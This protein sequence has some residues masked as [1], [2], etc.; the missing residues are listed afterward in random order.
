MNSWIII[1]SLFCFL[2]LAVSLI[3]FFKKSEFN[4]LFSL[5]IFMFAFN[6]FFNILYWMQLESA[7]YAFF[8]FSYYIPLSLYGALFYLYLRGIVYK[9]RLTRKDAFHFIPVALTLVLYGGFYFLKPS[10]KYQV[11]AEKKIMDYII[12]VPYYEQLL[13]IVLGIYTVAIFIKFRNSFPDDGELRVWVHYTILAFTGFTLSFVAYE[14]LMLTGV[15]RV[16]HDY[17][18]S[19]LSALFIG[20]V[21]Y[22][23]YVY[24]AVFNGKSIQ[25]VLP[26]VKYK[27]T[28]LGKQ[29]SVALKEKLIAIIESEKPYLNCDL[30]LIHIA[31]MLDVPRHHASQIINEHFKAG[32]F[33]FINKYRVL[34][35]ERIMQTDTVHHTMESIAYQ[36]G[37]NNRISFYKAFKKFNGQT[38]A[39]YRAQYS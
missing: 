16:E 36:S 12:H 18:I 28:G 10:I 35:S 26:F 34:E 13:V 2:G 14:M 21:S 6:M 1:L 19:I 15:L 24:P 31:D 30:R 22:G 7:F 4:T 3:F 8:L 39:A 9:K 20:I 32:F 5:L 17:I 38:P 11:F 25:E 29:E 27:K 37:F 33:D 23:A